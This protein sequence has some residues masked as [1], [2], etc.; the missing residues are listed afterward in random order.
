MRYFTRVCLSGIVLLVLVGVSFAQDDK[1]AAA[2]PEPQ[3][4]AE[5]KPADVAVTVKEISGTAHRLLTG[6]DPQWAPL[7]VGDKLDE[8]TIIRTGFRTKVVLTFTDNSEVVIE[9]A[10][11][12]GIREFRKEGEVTRTTL[13][14][15]YGSLRA[16][17]KK[18]AGPNDF[19]I[20]TPV[21]TAA[22]RGSESL[23]SFS[24]D[25][26][27][28]MRCLSGNWNVKKGAGSRNLVQGESTNNNL[29]ASIDM[30]KKKTTPMLGDVYGGLSQG[31]L[32]Y[33]RNNNGGRGGV[34][35]T[36]GGGL[37]SK[38]VN[39]SIPLPRVCEPPPPP[40]PPPENN[41]Y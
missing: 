23:A 6:K 27:Y 38:I 12:M 14:L 24:G 9:R 25:F 39:R 36:P 4:Q 13:G 22:A 5:S 32:R 41:G 33:I 17:V 16:T 26:G 7:K 8:M 11:K 10:T 15:K 20:A 3:K 35:F 18:A 19:R 40:P 34:G 37:T 21:A 28:E 1:T 2:K 31:E 29:L 30:A